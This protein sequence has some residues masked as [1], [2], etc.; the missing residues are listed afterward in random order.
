MPD[1]EERSASEIAA[2]ERASRA[3]EEDG[4]K[5]EYK[6]EPADTDDQKEAY[7]SSWNKGYEK[8]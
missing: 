6:P 5:N 2:I 3:G 4:E 7:D 1:E 8:R